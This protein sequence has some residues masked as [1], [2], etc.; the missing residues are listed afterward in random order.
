MKR[1]KEVPAGYMAALGKLYGKRP[2][3]GTETATERTQS[4]E[5]LPV[6]HSAKG[7]QS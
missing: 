1:R 2:I 7:K 5:V 6:P 3:A 4:T